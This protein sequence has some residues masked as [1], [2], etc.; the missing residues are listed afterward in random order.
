MQCAPEHVT[1]KRAGRIIGG[2]LGCVA[3]LWLVL[4]IPDSEPVGISG[5]GK[6]AF[7]WNRDAFWS[8]L[9]SHFQAARSAGCASLTNDIRKALGKASGVLQGISETALPSRAPE[10]LVLETNLF[11]L[12][13][14]VAACPEFLADYTAL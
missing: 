6:Q 8:Q 12:A 1:R 11:R 10:F 2:S 13:P 14:L 5:A 4:L 7:V 9:E 3:A